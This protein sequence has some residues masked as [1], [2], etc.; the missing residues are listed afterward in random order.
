MASQTIDLFIN[1]TTEG[2]ESLT[3]VVNFT[4]FLNVKYATL[5]ATIHANDGIGSPLPTEWKFTKFVVNGKTFSPS[6]K[7]NS[8]VN[9]HSSQGS[10]SQNLLKVNDVNTIS[11]HWIAPFGA[12][13]ISPHGAITA[14]LEVI[15]DSIPLAGDLQFDPRNAADDISRF[16]KNASLP[17]ALTIIAIVAILALVAFIL[18]KAVPAITGTKELVKEVKS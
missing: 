10:N 9:V 4:G 6:G 17:T 14:Q 7:L 2:R 13:V 16:T 11:I 15:G 1:E 5:K 12:G 18:V 3:K 8:T